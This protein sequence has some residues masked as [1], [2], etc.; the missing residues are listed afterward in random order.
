MKKTRLLTYLWTF[1]WD[2]I[3]WF[4]IAQVTIARG[5]KFAWQDYGLW[6]ILPTRYMRKRRGKGIRGIALCHGGFLSKVGFGDSEDTTETE[7]HEGVHVEL[8]EVCTLVGLVLGL[9]VFTWLFFGLNT[10]ISAC[11][12]GGLIW[13]GLYPAV[14]GAGHVVAKVR[15]ED[16]YLG[17]SHEEAARAIA[18]DKMESQ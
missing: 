13:L 1:V 3:M 10:P 5:G 7:A 9:I 11:V 4:V 15:G 18:A 8:Y 16:I 17:A 14:I 2:L 6:G 12:L